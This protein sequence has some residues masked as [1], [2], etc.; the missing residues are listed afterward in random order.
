MLVREHINRVGVIKTEFSETALAPVVPLRTH[1][2]AVDAAALA[3][4]G[5]A[6]FVLR[7]F[8]LGYA[9]LFRTKAADEVAAREALT[10]TTKRY[11]LVRGAFL[12]LPVMFVRLRLVPQHLGP[13]GQLQQGVRAVWGDKKRKKGMDKT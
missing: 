7:A 6:L 1:A 13:H 11:H 4:R 10:V 9:T 5:V 2:G 3:V 12:R 8:P